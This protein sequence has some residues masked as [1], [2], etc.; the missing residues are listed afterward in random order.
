[1][2]S[3]IPTRILTR[4]AVLLALTIA[5]QYL[6][7][8]P[9]LMGPLVNFMLAVSAVLVG[10]AAGVFIGS[11]TPW[12]ALLIGILP[13]PLAPAVPFIMVGNA[14]YCLLIGILAKNLV[15]RSIGVVLGSLAKYA[16]ISGAAA[17]V[18]TL[19]SA[20]AQALLLPQ[21]VNALLG[22]LV[23]LSTAYSV[24]WALSQRVSS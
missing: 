22:G 10:P 16:V 11:V 19:P 7:F 15:F 24:T 21:L 12:I 17:Y 3:I 18:L 23:A 20:L 5:V 8:P 1:M 9:P 13:V 2:K 6:G 4:T 14:V